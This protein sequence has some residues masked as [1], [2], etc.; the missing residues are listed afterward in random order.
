MVIFFLDRVENIVGNGPSMVFTNFSSTGRR[1][2]S[3]RHAVVSIVCAFGHASVRKL[4]LQKTF[5]QKL[6][7]GF[8]P[9][10]TAMFL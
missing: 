10:F 8:L 7:T 2:A 1:S 4:C 9:N 5:P 3:N 6:L